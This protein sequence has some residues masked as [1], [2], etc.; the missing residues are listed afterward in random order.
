MTSTRLLLVNAFTALLVIGG[1]AGI[2][3]ALGMMLR[4]PCAWMA[5]VAALD[6]ALLLYLSGVPRGRRRAVSALLITVAAIAA[7]AFAMA[8]SAIGVIFGTLPHVAIWQ[9]GPE[10][11]LTW[12]RM[13]AVGLDALMVTLAL[14]LAWWVGR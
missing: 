13:N 2:W 8:A 3:V 6:A 9:I 11:A 7:G 4:S 1:V 12:W 5:P 10:L 14:P